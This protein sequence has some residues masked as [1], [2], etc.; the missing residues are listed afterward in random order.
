MCETL[1]LTGQEEVEV[2]SGRSIW[3]VYKWS[4]FILVHTYMSLGPAKEMGTVYPVGGL[5]MNHSL[6]EEWQNK[7]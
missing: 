2:V 3:C 4:L 6:V 7:G 1:P 5:R